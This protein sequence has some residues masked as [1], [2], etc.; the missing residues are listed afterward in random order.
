MAKK[1]K[2]LG[3][4]KRF[5]SRYGRSAREKIGK[6][7]TVVRKAHKCPQCNKVK[8]KR[9]AVGIWAC[10]GCGNKFASQAFNPVLRFTKKKKGAEE[11]GIP[12]ITIAP[13]QEE[14]LEEDGKI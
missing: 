1:K 10:S 3:P 4:A 5:G 12:A 11:I 7:E 2:M 13:D 8:V 14:D 9:I 6:I